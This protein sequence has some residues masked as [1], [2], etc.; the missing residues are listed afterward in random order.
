M[1]YLTQKKGFTLI[2]LPVV[3]KRGL[4]R[5]SS[6]G[7]TLIE[8]LIVI[9]IIIIIASLVIVSVS[10]ARS[11][12]RD[13]K[14]IADLSTIQLALEMYREKNQK[15]PPERDGWDAAT[16]T[17]TVQLNWEALNVDLSD[18]LSPLPKDPLNKPGYR[19]YVDMENTLTTLTAGPTGAR[20]VTKLEDDNDAMASDVC[21]SVS[22]YYVVVLGTFPVTQDPCLGIS[23]LP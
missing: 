14:R 9:G 11:R 10:K 4:P 18:Y 15:Y 2:E 7:F 23:S 16:G 20:I 5:A 19:Y 8:L 22:D 13:A 1:K 3:K 6:R 12:G 17:G 21:S